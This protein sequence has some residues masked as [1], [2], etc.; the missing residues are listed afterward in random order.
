[1]LPPFANSGLRVCYNR[2]MTYFI[3]FRLTREGTVLDA[4]EMYCDESE[5]RERARA[6]AIN[7]PVELWQG[8]R[9]IARYEPGR[10]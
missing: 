8:P 7:S 5:A 4:T 6:L 10:A 1:V 2:A 3:A 9:R